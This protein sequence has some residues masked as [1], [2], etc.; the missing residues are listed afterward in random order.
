MSLLA[1]AALE[2]RPARL[3]DGRTKVRLI[4]APRTAGGAALMHL[5]GR[6]G[7]IVTLLPLDGE[8]EGI[9]TSGLRYPLRDETLRLGPARGLSNVR[10]SA[11]AAVTV[12]NGHL[13][14]IESPATLAP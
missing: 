13:L 3:L 5:H 4:R 9:T 14:V 7:D 8:V 2:E 6:L 11:T 12:R 1:L 10:T